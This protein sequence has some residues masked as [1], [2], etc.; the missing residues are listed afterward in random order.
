MSREAVDEWMRDG[1][2]RQ[3]RWARTFAIAGVLV[4]VVV[5]AVSIYVQLNR[6]EAGDERVLSALRSA[7]LTKPKLGGAD[8]AAC[9]DSESSRHFTATNATNARV[10]G[11]VCCGL[12]GVGKGCTI[13]WGR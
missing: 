9:A 4:A 12:T 5:I 13:R 6:V 10:E 2:K 7:G 8:T 3:R 11:T 1:E